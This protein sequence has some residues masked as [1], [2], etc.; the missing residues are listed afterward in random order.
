MY[1]D[2]TCVVSLYN[3]CVGATKWICPVPPRVDIVL[4]YGNGI[5]ADDYDSMTSKVGTVK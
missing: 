4:L 5:F 2:G 1:I 3:F